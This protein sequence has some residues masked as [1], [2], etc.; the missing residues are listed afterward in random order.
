EMITQG[1]T[2]FVLKPSQYINDGAL[3]GDFCRDVMNKVGRL[4]S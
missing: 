4:A 2:T 1:F 3:L